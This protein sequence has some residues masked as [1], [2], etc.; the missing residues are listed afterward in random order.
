M[1]YIH[2]NHNKPKLKVFIFY[3]TSFSL[4]PPFIY[5]VEPLFWKSSDFNHDFFPPHPHINP[6]GSQSFKIKL[7]MVSS[8]W[9]SCHLSRWLQDLSPVLCSSDCLH[10]LAKSRAVYHFTKQWGQLN[11][12][13]HF[14]CFLRHSLPPVITSNIC[15]QLFF[16]TMWMARELGG[17]RT[18]CWREVNMAKIHCTEL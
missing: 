2:L 8:F 4:S 10:L 9:P 12:T 18:N 17:S 6:R 1:F 14:C 11:K 16:K 13:S 3:Q 5:T 7:Q 15:L